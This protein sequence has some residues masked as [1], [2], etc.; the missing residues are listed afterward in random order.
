MRG[1]KLGGSSMNMKEQSGSMRKGKKAKRASDPLFEAKKA[2]EAKSK[3]PL[4]SGP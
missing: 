3:K 4:S 2:A 1:K